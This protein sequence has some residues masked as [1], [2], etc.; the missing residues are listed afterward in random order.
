MFDFLKR[1]K[2]V[3]GISI[4]SNPPIIMHCCFMLTPDSFKVV[5]KRSNLTFEQWYKALWFM[6]HEP[7]G[8]T[9]VTPTA[10]A[11]ELGVS[12]PTA[13]RIRQELLRV[14]TESHKEA[15]DK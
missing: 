8:P 14:M 13:K 11:K 3:P 6:Q 2:I 12:W 1:K 10:I 4:T 5:T 15:P 7:G 9:S